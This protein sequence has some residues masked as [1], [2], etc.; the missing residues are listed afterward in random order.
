MNDESDMKDSSS[1]EES[2]S[3][4]EEISDPEEEEVQKFK[5]WQTTHTEKT[6]KI[7]AT[8]PAIKKIHTSLLVSDTQTT[9][10]IKPEAA[11]KKRLVPPRK[12]EK[13]YLLACFTRYSCIK[14]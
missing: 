9:N 10:T 8:T 6:L 11:K 12:K 2:S 14:S 7:E 4:I 5:V 1:E 13:L 3:D